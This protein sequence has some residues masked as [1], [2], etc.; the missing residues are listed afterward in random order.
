MMC[1]HELLTLFAQVVENAPASVAIESPYGTLTYRDLEDRANDLARVLLALDVPQNS[2]LAVLY[3]NR[4]DVILA[5]LTA[6]KVGCIFAPLDPA[7]PEARLHAM[8]KGI[9][10][11]WFLTESS[12]SPTIERMR[13]VVSD[14]TILFSDTRRMTVASPG[15]TEAFP[16]WTDEQKVSRLSDPDAICYIYFTSGST[17]EPKRIAGSRRA[18]EH[19]INWEIATFHIEAGT[20][21][22]QFSHPTFDA[23]LRDVF[24]PLCAGGTMCLPA[25]KETIADASKLVRFL[26]QQRINLVHCVPSLFRSILSQKLASSD[27]SALSYILLAG[28]SLLPADVKRWVEVYG[29]RIRLVNLYGAS[30]T[31]MVK[32]FYV[33]KASD[34]DRQSIPVGQPLGGA[35]ALV[36]DTKRRVCPPGIVGE[37]YIQTPFRLPG[38]Y[39]QPDLTEQAFVPHPLNGSDGLIYKS[40]DLGRLLDDGNLE[41]L[42]RK[43]RQVKVRGVRV[44]IDEIE[45]LLRTHQAVED[46]AVTACEDAHGSNYLCAYVVLNEEIAPAVLRELL[47]GTL[48]DAMIPSAYVIMERLPRTI[49]GKVDRKSLPAPRQV[50]ADRP[51][52][53]VPPRSAVE[54]ILVN[55]WARILG[56]EQ[57]GIQDN[58]FEL[59]GHS[60]LATQVNSQVRHT[61]QVEL[62]LG[63]LLQA[64]TIAGLAE[65]IALIQRP[66]QQACVLPPLQALARGTCF[67]LSFAQQRLWFIDQFDP[68]SAAY[69]VQG[70]LRIRGNLDTSALERALQEIVQR[71]GALRTTFSTRENQPVQCIDS[72]MRIPLQQEDLSTFPADEQ[73]AE[74]Q[75]RAR[76]EAQKPFQLA[77]GPLLKVLLLRLSQDVHVLLLIMHHIV[78][79]IWSLGVFHRELAHLYTA[80]SSNRPA[81]L[82]DLPVQ[83]T[84]FTLWQ[85]TWLQGEIL[86]DLVTYWKRQLAG[87][88]ELLELPA[89]RPRPAIQRFAGAHH[90][91]VVP[92]PLVKAL[93][94]LSRQAGCTFFTTLI[95]AFQTL[96]TRYTGQTDIVVGT[97][98][99][100]RMRSELEGLIG[101]FVNTLVVRTDLSGDPPFHELLARVR[102][103]TLGAYAHQDMPFEQL[104]EVLRPSRDLSHTPLFQVAFVLQNTPFP[105]LDMGDLQVDLLETH[106]GTSNFDLSLTMMEDSH[107]LR[108]TIEY[109]TD[110]FDAARMVR[111]AEHFQLLLQGIATDPYQRIST[112]PLLPT[113]ELHRLSSVQKRSYPAHSSVHRLF[114][115][116]VERTPDAV[117]LV[118][119]GEMLTYRELNRRA[120]QLAHC[121]Q[122]LGVGPEVLVAICL[123][124]S[125]EMIVAVLA[126]LKAGG[127]YVPLDPSYP[128]ERLAFMLQDSQAV[129][130]LLH[131]W[132]RQK[133]AV[134]ERHVLCL[135]TDWQ[136]GMARERE[137]NPES[138]VSGEQLAYVIYTSGSTGQPKGVLIP[139]R[140]LFNHAMAFTEHCNLQARDRILQFASL[141]FD[142]A[143]EEVFPALLM[144]ATLVVRSNNALDLSSF[145]RLVEEERLT[146]LDLPTAYWHLWLAHLSHS[147]PVPSSLRLVIVG[148][149]KVA[150]ERFSDW[151]RWTGGRIGWANTYGPT[152]TT[153]TATIYEPACSNGEEGPT[154]IP[155]GRPLPNVRVRVLDRLLQ[156]VPIG[157]P[158]ELYIGGA[159]L[160]RGYLN[161]PDLTGDR[162]FPDPLSET[163]G[164]YLYRTGDLACFLPEGDLEFLGRIDQQVK[165]RGFRVEPA[166]IEAILSQHPAVQDAAVLVRTVADDNASLLAYVVPCPGHSIQRDV[167][168]QYLQEKLPEYM[169]PTGYILLDALPLTANGKVDRKALLTSHARRQGQP[170]RSVALPHTETEQVLATIWAGLLNLAQIGVHDNFFELGGHSFLT[171]R[172]LDSIHRHFQRTLLL[173]TLFKYPT[174]AQLAGVLDQSANGTLSPCWSPLVEIQAGCK[175]PLFF[176]HPISGS[177]LCYTELA[178]ALGPDQPFYGLQARGLDGEQEPCT[179]IEE[180]AQRYLEALQ[181]VQP[182][183]PYL[184]GGWSLGGLIAFEIA[185][186]L[187]TQGQGVALLA[188]VDSRGYF[189]RPCLSD[190]DDTALMV[191]FAQELEGYFAQSLSVSRAN[192]QHLQA[193]EQLLYVHEQA[194]SKGLVSRETDPSLLQRLFHLF[195]A[196]MQALSRYIPR[197]YPGRIT[198]FLTAEPGVDLLDA[199]GDWV[200]IA[201]EGVERYVIPGNH[202]TLVREPHVQCLSDQLKACIGI[203]E[204]I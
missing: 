9:A 36:L 5:L 204:G 66:G 188:L 28:E 67:P 7:I 166:E 159:G 57:V 184:L 65:R 76:E 13:E 20:R 91:F 102:E 55:I 6:L 12:C 129:V 196:N 62:S 87:A 154:S 52:T 138:G 77:R 136:Q 107:G 198:L 137:E 92:Q 172:M 21:V 181:R 59:G 32:C 31:T 14:A 1:Q 2:V 158:G 176:V 139:H 177:I 202:F 27:L 192:I 141:S 124:R 38:Y 178:R 74:I 185:Q 112:I 199:T 85:R 167:L 183:G 26:E 58:F 105:S 142:A 133:L 148:G 126:V 95:A 128:A 22:S 53:L 197:T 43:D 203:L 140:S 186:R 64:P 60:L 157:V 16:S 44:E 101:F 116:Q 165:I 122:R 169:R 78:F 145:L 125:P 117:A 190:E 15:N 34:K 75:K 11:R 68:E 47:S 24:V 195:K 41:Y 187:R 90:S 63:D 121:L 99:A 108:G 189:S 162:F 150:V 35:K 56:L 135:D 61:L 171:I 115:A 161:R 33:V 89:D 118:F 84:D 30:E 127:A 153:I 23:F 201:S 160:A 164:A 170:E 191:S 155:I 81:A 69:N 109:N 111:L 180:M 45:N 83:Y 96:L 80:F 120:N 54:E 10:P 71:H 119:E 130:V 110:L 94:A 193:K 73:A 151:Y 29:E 123:E 42:G 147:T 88:P 168:R 173:P 174:I 132:L 4:V 82:P 194:S 106:H 98:I 113:A 144:G 18:I 93:K 131:Q 114:E 3:N 51:R 86:A 72:S 179:S 48:P 8:I 103:V 182:D 70:A 17:G 49:S 163:P 97:P 19:F 149:E 100:N 146:V 143:A 37:I 46:V 134:E 25:G 79:D 152:E 156:P 39:N 50:A 104:V 175:R 40:G 200:S